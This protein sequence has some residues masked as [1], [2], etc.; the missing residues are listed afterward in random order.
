MG[1]K[2]KSTR[3]EVRIFYWRNFHHISSCCCSTQ[4]LASSEDGYQISILEW[5]TEMKEEVYVAQPPGFEQ[6]ES[7]KKVCKL[8]KALYGLKQAP[9][10]WY[11]KIESF[12]LLNRSSSLSDANLSVFHERK[13]DA[14]NQNSVCRWYCLKRWSWKIKETQQQ[15]SMEFEMTESIYDSSIIV[16]AFQYGGI[17]FSHNNDMLVRYWRHS[18]SGWQNAGQLSHRI[19]NNRTR[20]EKHF[21]DFLFF[22]EE[23][24]GQGKL[25]S[26]LPKRSRR[27]L[28]QNA[29]G[30]KLP[31][32][33][34][35]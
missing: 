6:P 18:D 5:A 32:I 21:L 33:E 28:T 19:S 9:R 30:V 11:H 24:Q 29:Q 20:W 3:N 10:A 17:S 27:L 35:E 12:F 2:Y 15:L 7:E 14:C 34:S 26:R 25:S 8:K 13:R 31:G 22:E 4:K 1:Q 16:W 23:N